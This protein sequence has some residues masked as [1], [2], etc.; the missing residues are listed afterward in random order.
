MYEPSEIPP[1]LVPPSGC[2]KHATVQLTD[3]T[4]LQQ[5]LNALGKGANVT[6]SVIGIALSY[7]ADPRGFVSAIALSTITSSLL[8]DVTNKSGTAEGK[9]ILKSFLCGG[10]INIVAVEMAR[11]ALRVFLHLKVPLKGVDAM[12][13]F[14]HKDPNLSRIGQVVWKKVEHRVRIDEVDELW[15]GPQDTAFGAILRAWITAR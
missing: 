5:R 11:V 3:P 13:Y 10:G 2:L 8:V 12:D 7:D 9:R 14:T 4:E 1:G 6:G 15:D